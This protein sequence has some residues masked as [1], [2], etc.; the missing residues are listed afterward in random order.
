MWGAMCLKTNKNP[1]SEAPV[2][3]PLDENLILSHLNQAITQSLSQIIILGA[4]ESTNSH[5]LGLCQQSMQSAIVC[6]AESQS[7]GRGRRGNH[8]ISPAGHNVYLSM[9]WRFPVHLQDLSGLSLAVGLAITRALKIHQ[10]NGLSLKWPNDVYCR[11]KKLAGILIDIVDTTDH[12]CLVVIGV[13][14]NRWID[15][16]SST[17]IDR[18]WIDLYS[19]MGNAMPSRNQLIATIIRHLVAV[20]TEF[21]IEGFAGFC[22]EWTDSDHLLGQQIVLTAGNQIIHGAAR[23]VSDAGLLMIEVQPG[24]VQSYSIGEVVLARQ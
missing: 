7:K 14:L 10:L 5:L 3:E 24:R 23:G 22:D 16:A 1:L 2:A 8:W 6:L 4:T 9:S 11:G 15:A 19:V 17:L 18:Q 20:I 12:D 21:E 13:G